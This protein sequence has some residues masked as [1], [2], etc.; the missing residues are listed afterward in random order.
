MNWA[1]GFRELAWEVWREDLSSGELP[2]SQSP[3]GQVRRRNSELSKSGG[4]SGRPCHKSTAPCS[5]ASC[6]GRARIQ[7][8]STRKAVGWYLHDKSNT[9]GT[10][11]EHHKPEF[12]GIASE[13]ASPTYFRDAQ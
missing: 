4:G 1:L 3:D 13:V 11:T 8:G 10:L 2:P 7:E 9:I 12:F 5:R 6:K